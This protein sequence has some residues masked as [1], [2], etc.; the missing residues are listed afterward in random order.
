MEKLDTWLDDVLFPAI[1]YRMNAKHTSYD[2]FKKHMLLRKIDCSWKNDNAYPI[3]ES[4]TYALCYIHGFMYPWR[5]FSIS[6]TLTEHDVVFYANPKS[7]AYASFAYEFQ[8]KMD[9]NGICRLLDLT[10]PN[11]AVMQLRNNIVNRDDNE[12]F[13]LGPTIILYPN[14]TFEEVLVER[15]LAYRV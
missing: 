6:R 3:I 2:D 10:L 14:E 1:H 4:T 8:S 5:M 11:D 15:D 12:D 13:R 7:K 9:N